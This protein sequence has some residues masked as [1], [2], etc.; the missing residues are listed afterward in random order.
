[1]ESNGA[2]GRPF[3]VRTL[4]DLAAFGDGTVNLLYLTTPPTA[5]RL[6]VRDV[7]N[8][9]AL[10]VELVRAPTSP[11][12]DNGRRFFRPPSSPGETAT[13]P[14]EH[15]ISVTPERCTGEP[16][17]WL[18]PVVLNCAI[19]GGELGGEDVSPELS[20]LTRSGA[21]ALSNQFGIP[22]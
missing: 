4:A 17:G 6:I 10:T 22:R 20:V 16:I 11:A 3:F 8:P 1:M 13:P 7:K 5:D 12:G 21:S 19:G 18:N 15:T 14:D 2:G 9:R